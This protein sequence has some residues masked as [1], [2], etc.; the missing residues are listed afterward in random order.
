MSRG[1]LHPT[2][3]MP[4]HF[5][6]SNASPFVTTALGCG[7]SQVSAAASIRATLVGLVSRRGTAG[8]A[9][10]RPS[11]TRKADRRI[12]DRKMK[13]NAIFL[14]SVFLSLRGPAAP[15]RQ[16]V[17]AGA[18]TRVGS[19]SPFKDPGLP[20]Q[21]LPP[22]V[23]TLLFFISGGGYSLIRLFPDDLHQHP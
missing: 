9:R 21:S 17:G 15:M 2:S 1:S 19:R 3:R 20:A 18:G 8:K 10:Q 6:R 16:L 13:P 14:S 7:R 11:G 22:C 12:E 4:L 5:L 23:L